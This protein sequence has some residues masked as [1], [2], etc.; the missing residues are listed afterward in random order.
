MSGKVSILHRIT[1]LILDCLRKS[2]T[3]FFPNWCASLLTSSLSS[4]NQYRKYFINAQQRTIFT[5]CQPTWRLAQTNLVRNCQGHSR[6][7]RGKC[8]LGQLHNQ[9]KSLE[10]LVAA[11][12]FLA[13]HCVFFSLLLWNSSLQISGTQNSCKPE[14][15]SLFSQA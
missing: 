12:L 11:G 7:H 14:C 6:L 5:P 8:N 13:G 2:L 9:A 4:A 1:M 15:G 10:E 3:P